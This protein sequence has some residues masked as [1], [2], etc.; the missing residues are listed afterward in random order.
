VS[1]SRDVELNKNR[2]SVD[3]SKW[4]KKN[5][6]NLNFQETLDRIWW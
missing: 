6:R 4:K 5:S 1:H 3:I 2:Q